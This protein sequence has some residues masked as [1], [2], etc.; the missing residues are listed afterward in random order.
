MDE[1]TRNLFEMMRRPLPPQEAVNDW[2]E[3]SLIA[4]PDDHA[5]FFARTRPADWHAILHRLSIGGPRWSRLITEIIRHEECDP[6]TLFLSYLVSTPVSFIL[7]GGPHPSAKKLAPHFEAVVRPNSPYLGEV[8]ARLREGPPG[9]PRFADGSH[10][11]AMYRTRSKSKAALLRSFDLD[12]PAEATL[13]GS[14]KARS[15]L[16]VDGNAIR[17]HQDAWYAGRR[18]KA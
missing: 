5:A 7:E 11:E 15:D 1:I 2:R 8:L 4:T 16:I 3:N 17:V 14:E 18:Y 6:A 12:I 13:S 10:L 9:N